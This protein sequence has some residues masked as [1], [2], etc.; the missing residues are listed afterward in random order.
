MIVSVSLGSAAYYPGDYCD[1]ENPTESLVTEALAQAGVAVFVSSGN[2]G[3]CDGISYPS[4][5]KYTIS[6]GSVYDA[7]LGVRPGEGLNY[8]I[9]EE[10][11]VGHAQRSPAPTAEPARTRRPGRTWCPATPTPPTSWTCWPRPSAP[12]SRAWAGTGP[13]SAGP[14][15]P[16]PWPPA[17]QPWSR[18]TPGP[19][20]AGS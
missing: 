18:A 1:Q 7:S 3:I 13:A 2:Y 19:P 10:S 9:Q 16:A 6:V 17:P 14:R 8:C 12:M 15:P 11:C 4:C 20:W 5:L